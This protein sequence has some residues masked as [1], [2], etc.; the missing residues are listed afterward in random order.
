[1]INIELKSPSHSAKDIEEWVE[2]NHCSNDIAN[3]LRKKYFYNG[4]QL[5]RSSK[6]R[7]VFTGNG[8]VLLKKDNSRAS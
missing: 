4:N 5:N 1:M 6:Y 8:G 3:R 7:I 2:E